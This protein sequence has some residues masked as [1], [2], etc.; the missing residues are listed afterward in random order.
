[1][2]ET[3]NAALIAQRSALLATVVLTR[4]LNI[5]VHP[6]GTAGD[7]GIDLIATIRPDADEELQGFLP[8]AVVV[9][10]TSKELHNANEAT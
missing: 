6:F 5:D 8:F 4:R 3:K 1:M 9:W 2:T 10:G 7:V